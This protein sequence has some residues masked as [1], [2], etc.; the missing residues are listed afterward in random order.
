MNGQNA[1]KIEVDVYFLCL[2]IERQNRSHF[3]QADAADRFIDDFYYLV[4]II[5]ILRR[6]QGRPLGAALPREANGVT[7]D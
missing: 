7:M 6:D 1:R 3:C 2:F 5:F 4:Y